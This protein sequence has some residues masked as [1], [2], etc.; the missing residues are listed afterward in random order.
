MKRIKRLKVILTTLLFLSAAVLFAACG[1]GGG[2]LATP[3]NLYLD[4][5]DNLNWSSV[6]N[7][8]TYNVEI[9]AKAD[10]SRTERSTR[11]TNTSLYALDVGDY[12]IRVRAVSGSGNASD[13][14][15]TIA[16]QRVPDAG[17]TYRAVEDNTAWALTSAR[18]SV[19]DVEIGDLYRGKPVIEISDGAFRNNDRVTS[20]SFGKFVRRVGERVFYNCIA[21]T[22]VTLPD[23]IVS[24]GESLFHGCSQLKNA[25]LPAAIDVIPNYTYAYCAALETVTISDEVKSIGESAFYSCTALKDV[26][27]PDS[28]E[29]IGQYAFSRDSAFTSVKFGSA[30]KSIGEYAFLR[31]EALTSV[32]F[33]PSY[34]TLELGRGIFSECTALSSV[35][36]PNG[37]SNIPESCFDGATAL[38]EVEIPGSVKGVGQLAFRNTKLLTEQEGWAYAGNWLISVPLETRMAL[39]IL[40]PDDF[41]NEEIVGIA[42]AVFATV[43]GIGC[44][45]MSS[46]MFPASLMYVGNYAFYQCEGLQ[47][48][49][50]PID[51]KLKEFGANAFRGCSFLSNPRLEN[52][53]LESIGDFAFYG[54]TVLSNRPDYPEQLVPSS[55]THIGQGAY[56]EAG[57]SSSEKADAYGVIYAGNWVVGYSG[58]TAASIILNDETVG[59]A[60]YAF[61]N[62]TELLTVEGMPHVRY[63]GEGAFLNCQ[64]LQEVSLSRNLTAIQPYTFFQCMS[65]STVGETLYSIREIGEYAFFQCDSLRSINL[66]G[67][68]VTE[69]GDFAFYSCGGAEQIVLN[70]GLEKIGDYAF[71]HN[72][73]TEIV[74]PDSVRS[75][76]S[77]AFALSEK[78]TNLKLNEGLLEI[79][80]YAF[81]YSLGLKE[82][83]IPNSVVSVGN[84]AFLQCINTETLVLGS[85]LERI[86]DYAFG[87][88]GA[89]NSVEFPQELHS[90]GEYAFVYCT[91]LKS[92]VLPKNLE[93][94]GLH[95]FYGCIGATFYTELDS[96]PE[97]WSMRWNSSYRPAVWGVTLSDEGYVYSISTDKSE[98][99]MARGGLAAPTRTGYQFLGWSKA[100]N[101]V[102]PE[103][104]NDELST[105][106]AGITLY[107]V[108]GSA[109]EIN[110]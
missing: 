5:D 8:R 2:S 81:R 48:I 65:L 54:C 3:A 6:E 11:R 106:P 38:A 31:D 47:K 86:G 59:I 85:G 91:G 92:V 89:L 37:V 98:G 100:E 109:N 87:V 80:D 66:A 77:H 105:L 74:M 26:E 58:S 50:T 9:V 78:L 107:A 72:L 51:S 95:A 70:D 79:G 68:S 82:I 84:A 108:Y 15:E 1:G 64:S 39:E 56:R 19:G 7:A 67:A 36:F 97:T 43:D 4:E 24:V 57:L 32:S 20:A 73:V 42:D 17:Y 93:Y 103:Y 13:W 22:S 63:L 94:V 44:P 12:D 99:T 46:V 28:V 52:T 71:Y 55:V 110:Q 14:S 34:E 40:S 45:K 102:E 62:D 33:A 101:A 88:M 75:I 104:T 35:V 25:D 41:G 49:E 21:L 83:V 10:G 27:I 69:I 53:K 76:G 61:A 60:D 16:F 90:I 23:S 96:A 18:A 29:T 30:L